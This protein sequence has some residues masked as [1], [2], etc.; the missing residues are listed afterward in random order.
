MKLGIPLLTVLIVLIAAVGCLQMPTQIPDQNELIPTLPDQNEF[1]DRNQ[2]PN[3]TRSISTQTVVYNGSSGYL[4]RPDDNQTYPGV[5]LIHEWWGLNE[6]MKNTAEKLAQE[7][8]V[9]LAVDLYNGEV[10]MDANRA[11]ELVSQVDANAAVA[12]MRSAT[13]YL[14][15]QP[16][17]SKI[18]SWGYCFG[19]GQSLN[20]ALSGEPLDATVI[21]YGTLKTDPS[22]LNV[23]KW[24]V[25]GVFGEEDQ[26]I[27]VADARQ[28]KTVLDQLGI[29]NQIEIYA[30]VGHAFANPSNPN[31]APAETQDAW[32][33]TVA[34]LNRNL[35]EN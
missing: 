24:P 17:V 2:I 4:A 5:V 21:Y 8:F 31:Y 14:A 34:F 19:G 13:Q 6:Q 35:K 22:D 18:A 30:N 23:I 20:L 33:K 12:N 3:D 29:E 15:N 7:G 1:P 16:D 28:F 26:S 32:T 10:A 11:Q 9:V 25:M 27:P